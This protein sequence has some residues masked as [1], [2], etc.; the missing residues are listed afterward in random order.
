MSGARR[1]VRKPPELVLEEG[2]RLLRGQGWAKRPVD[3]GKCL[4]QMATTT[5]K[6]I[7]CLSTTTAS[8]YRR[9]V[10]MNEYDLPT[11]VKR[12]RRRFSRV[13]GSW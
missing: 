2:L 7:T 3:M 9:N 4:A 10:K 1:A 5:R 6:T 13:L 11:A 8:I 12:N